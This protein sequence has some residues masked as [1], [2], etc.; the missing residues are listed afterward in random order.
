MEISSNYPWTVTI[1]KLYIFGKKLDK[2]VL[3]K[4][5]DEINAT[6]KRSGE[7]K[8]ELN[9][10]NERIAELQKEVLELTKNR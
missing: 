7:L 9:V 1:I 2:T 8:S 3:K 6:E 4:I 5:E 10:K